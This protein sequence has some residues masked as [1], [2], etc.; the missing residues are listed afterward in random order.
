MHPAVVY[1]V[2]NISFADRSCAGAGPRKHPGEMSIQ[3]RRAHYNQSEHCWGW[4]YE[5]HRY[6]LP[7]EYECCS[8]RVL[9][10]VTA[11]GIARADIVAITSPRSTIYIFHYAKS[12][13]GTNWANFYE[14]T[15]VNLGPQSWFLRMWPNLL[16]SQSHSKETTCGTRST[17]T[18][19][20]GIITTPLWLQSLFLYVDIFIYGC[21]AELYS[22]FKSSFNFSGKLPLQN[23]LLQICPSYSNSCGPLSLYLIWRSG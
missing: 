7:T 20:W 5:L 15:V 19:Q 17:T 2:S 4:R 16:P 12:L 6:P 22:V 1:A 14:F 13:G 3:Q 23:I 8:N 11:S 21:E 18:T 9:Y 10:T